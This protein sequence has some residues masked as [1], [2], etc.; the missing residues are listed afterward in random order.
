LI[1]A[2]T[3]EVKI[4]PEAEFMLNEFWI[5]AKVQRTLT[6]RGYNALFRI[7]IYI[8]EF[9]EENLKTLFDKRESDNI[10]WVIKDE[11]TG[12]PKQVAPEPNINDTFKLFLK[13]FAFLY[14]AEYITPEMKQQYR[15]EAIDQGLLAAPNTTI[16]TTATTT[17]PPKGTYT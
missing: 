1:Y 8:L 9:N 5:R 2:N 6:I 4:T 16:S 10:N 11:R 14:N 3:I 17:S 12:T 15:L 7:A 13:P